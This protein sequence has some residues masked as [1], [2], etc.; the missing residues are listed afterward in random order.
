M[1]FQIIALSN[2]CIYNT[3]ELKT[4]NIKAYLMC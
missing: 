2:A 3:D 1:Y 4:V